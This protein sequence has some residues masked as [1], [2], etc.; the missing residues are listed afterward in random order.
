MNKMTSKKAGRRMQ[1]ATDHAKLTIVPID[2]EEA[3]AFVA[4]WHR[5][6]A[7][8]PA[9]GC[10][11]C[12]AVATDHIVGVAI[13]GRPNARE[14]QDGWTLQVTRTATDGTK[15]ACSM[16][17]AAC[18][19]AARALGYRRGVTYT[20]PGESGASLRAAGWRIIGQTRAETW[21][22]KD[23]PRVDTMPAQAKLR[24]MIEASPSSRTSITDPKGATT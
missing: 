7:H 10:K 9:R 4:Q 13:A 20:L 8:A 18:W 15:N 21:D 16:L 12:C 22:R 6:L 23:R 17:Y 2:L 19:R 5:H 24:W 11:F 1:T 3:N 14:Y